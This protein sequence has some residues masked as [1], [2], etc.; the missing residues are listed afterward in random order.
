MIVTTLIFMAV[1]IYVLFVMKRAQM[2]VWYFIFGSVGLF[3]FSMILIE[4]YLVTPLS[5]L[6]TSV[7]GALGELTGV[8]ESYFR[9][10]ILFVTSG[11][12]SLSLYIDFECSGVI[13]MIAFLSLLWFFWAYNTVEKIVMSMIGVGTIFVSNILRIFFICLMIKIGGSDVY[14]IAHTIVGR[15]IFYVCTV[16]LYFYVFTRTQIIRQKVGKFNYD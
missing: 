2:G 5:R 12:E 8:F 15:L 14:F 4:P 11:E 6:V 1:W 13:E 3:V 16:I 7:S 9:H 10:G